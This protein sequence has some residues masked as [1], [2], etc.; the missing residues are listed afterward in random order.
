MLCI[1]RRI[2]RANVEKEC[3][4]NIGNGGL[5]KEIPDL[6]HTFVTCNGVKDLYREV[7]RIMEKVFKVSI[8]AEE[9]VALSFMERNLMKMRLMLWFGIKVMYGIYTKVESTTLFLGIVRELEWCQQNNLK[10]G[11]FEMML[12]LREEIIES[13]N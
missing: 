12:K 7:I 3:K 2:H 5:C 8:K 11:N 13:M 6:M 10:V 9:M 1:G 4:N